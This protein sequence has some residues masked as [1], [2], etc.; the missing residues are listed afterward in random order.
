M[1][2]IKTYKLFESINVIWKPEDS[3]YRNVEVKDFDFS[4]FHSKL[5][6]PEE[7]STKNFINDLEDI[8][9]EISD[10]N[11]IEISF[12]VLDDINL[13]YLPNYKRVLNSIVIDINAETVSN[14]D[15]LFP[16]LQ[17][18]EE[19]AE[20]LEVAVAESYLPFESVNEFISKRIGRNR[21]GN[22]VVIIY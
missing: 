12:K 19:Y 2:H 20:G 8:C 11:N 1:K 15:G 17:R 5:H 3:R 13:D 21:I 10:N 4:K 14:I 7:Q 16:T 18:I 9:V 6:T 22:V